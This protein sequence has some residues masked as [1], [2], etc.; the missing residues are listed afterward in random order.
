MRAIF[1]AAEKI[2]KMDRPTGR[3]VDMLLLARPQYD[4]AFVGLLVA[5]DEKTWVLK[6][7][8]AGWASMAL[9]HFFM[10][11]RF[12]NTPS[13]RQLTQ[14]NI[15]R[16]TKMAEWI[17]V[18]QTECDATIADVLGKSPPQGVSRSDRIKPLPTP[19]DVLKQGLLK[20]GDY[21]ELGRLLYQQWKFLCDPAHVGIGS[22]WLRETIRGGYGGA[23]PPHS[24]EDFIWNHVVQQAIL[25]S[26]VAIVTVA[27]VFGFRR[28]SNAELL[29][30]IVKAWQPLESGSVEGSI[31]WQGWARRALGVLPD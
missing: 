25:P 3:W 7:G 21:E 19:G 16:L 12:E 31:I 2:E 29:A 11:R 23:I 13:G 9:R 28:R 1:T 18:T 5:Q 20:G 4:A 26:L 22:L 8:K 24:R 14:M 6:Y 15:D 17:G 27:S 30:A 10:F